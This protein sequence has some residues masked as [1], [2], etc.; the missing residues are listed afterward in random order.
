MVINDNVGTGATGTCNVK[1][2]LKRIEVINGGFDY[3]EEPII[4]ITGG[5]GFGAAAQINTNMITHTESFNAENSVTT[6][7]SSNTIGFSTFHK[8]RNS[9]QIIY[10]TDNQTGIAG[11]V[12]DAK[13]YVRTIDAH[14]VSLHLTKVDA[15][16]NTNTLDLT[17]LGVGIQRLEA[18]E[19]KKVISN[20]T[21]V[22]SGSNY[23]NKER[24][25]SVSGIN[26]ALGYINIPN[27]KYAS[28]ELVRYTFTGTQVSGLNSNTSYYVTVID[29]D[30]F[31][32]S[33]VGVGTTTKSFFYDT[34]Q[35]INFNSVGSGNHKFN[36][37][38]IS[39][40]VKGKIGVTTFA[41]QSFE[42][43][44]QPVFRGTIESVQVTDNGVGYGSSDII[45]FDRQP[46]VTVFSG[47][48]AELLPIVSN[49]RI[50]EV[51]VTKPGSGYNAPPDLIVS[52][53]GKNATLVAV[54]KNGQIS[55]VVVKDPGSD[56][57]DDI[58]VTVI[59]AGSGAQFNSDL[60][61]W[62]VNLFQKYF[63]IFTPDDGI[64]SPSKNER[65]GIQ[66]SHIYAPR[67]IRESVFSKSQE[68]EIRYGTV[69]LL[70]INNLET[71]SEYHS[72]IIG[73]AYDGNPI[74]GP[75][76]YD[77][78]TGGI[79]RSM[80]SGYE[81]Q[82][83][84]ANR[85]NLFSDGFFVNDYTFTGNGDLDEH[86]GR[87]CITPDYP[88]GVYAYFTTINPDN[89]DSSGPFKGMKA[90][91]FPYLIGNSYRSKPDSFNFEFNT[92]EN[93][94][95]NNSKYFRN[96]SPYSLDTA[97]ASY[98]YLFQPDS[99]R[100]QTIN[101]NDTSKGSIQ[102]VGIIT[103]GNGYQVGDKIQ[104]ETVTEYPTTPANA[105]V[106][107]VGGKVV[108]SVSVASSS[109]DFVEIV[110]LRL[111]TANQYVAFSTAPNLF[112]GADIVNVEGIS[113]SSSYLNGSFAVGITSSFFNLTTGV[114]TA[115]VTG[116][117]TYFDIS[118]EVLTD[119]FNIRENDI[120]DIG[121]ERIRIL[122]VDGL[123][124][125]VRVQ[126]SVEGTVSTAHTA[127]TQLVEN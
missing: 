109:I 81:L 77:T 80:K 79:V 121:S 5:N 113:T 43:D 3:V 74:Y 68:N 72:P 87:F 95:L 22:E 107:R 35:Y 61:K 10:R 30:N 106:S 50:Q 51:L 8:F 110:P 99:V 41:G 55:R 6:G 21:V 98:N 82:T 78:P 28:G 75:Y 58:S 116:I 105:R 117:V 48:N 89:L 120:Y 102:S 29:E 70:R 25:T 123:N 32:L 69:D 100:S 84:L 125:R 19:K 39:V 91:Q 90:P 66:Y 40:S 38:P 4:T 44:I 88:N 33:S 45:D 119:I 126:R 115:G 14:T 15:I 64:L 13:Y 85:P 122:N 37:E 49:G 27:H 1:G 103:G 56:Y 112:S 7:I 52:G 94:D 60:Q 97:G 73:W 12:T 53:A 92:Q 11:I 36:Y 31:A 104:F 108:N 124:S 62:N 16:S 20:I 23:E 42:A 71:G 118:G 93:F 86:N 18:V 47:H 46:R 101:I 67:S 83:N 54:L 65:Y 63:D 17:A 127:T 59:P 24:T 96:T 114:G 26:T 57:T 76:G 9:E 2:S 34:A 111:S